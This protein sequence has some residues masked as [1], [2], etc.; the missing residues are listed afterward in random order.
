MLNIKRPKFLDLFVLG[1]KMAVMAKISILHRLSGIIL[2]LSIPFL[3]FVLHRSLTNESFYATLYGICSCTLVKL[4]YLIIIWSFMH[5]IC[6]GVRFLLLDVN[7]GADIKVA[8]STAKL[9]LVLSLLFTVLLGVL[10][11]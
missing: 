10:I 3:L 8:R 4:L 11:W 1:P 5:H 2:F 7:K 9:V 6:A